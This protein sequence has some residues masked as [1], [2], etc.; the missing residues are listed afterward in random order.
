[1]EAP[2]E[3]ASIAAPKPMSVADILGEAEKWIAGAADAPY[4]GAPLFQ[5][6]QH[7]PPGTA[8]VLY[9]L[10]ADDFAA[11]IA[12]AEQPDPPFGTVVAAELMDFPANKSL[13][14]LHVAVLDN[15]WNYQLVRVRV[16]RNG[17]D[18]NGNRRVDINPA[19]GTTSAFSEWTSHGRDVLTLDAER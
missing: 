15:V 1:E 4:G 8:T 6:L 3:S 18:I 9:S 14:V 11:P 10:A 17:I 7:Q 16:L 5:R 2:D 12:A 13:S 19:F